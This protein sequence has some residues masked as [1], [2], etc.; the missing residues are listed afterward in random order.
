MPTLID[1]GPRECLQET[2]H[3]PTWPTPVELDKATG[4]FGLDLSAN[5]SFRSS[6]FRRF[7]FDT[8]L[9]STHY[10]DENDLI[11]RIIELGYQRIVTPNAL[12]RHYV[13]DES[14]KKQVPLSA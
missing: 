10:A 4:C 9:K 1:P 5:M 8:G 7:R 12:A 11:G 14:Y 13:R 6:I 2:T 3:H